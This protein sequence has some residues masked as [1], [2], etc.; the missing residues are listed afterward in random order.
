MSASVRWP[1]SFQPDRQMVHLLRRW[2][3]VVTLLA[4]HAF[5]FTSAAAAQTVNGR[6]IGDSS[7]APIVNLRVLLVDSVSRRAV[8]STN[9][10]SSGAFY[11]QA[12][13]PGTYALAFERANASPSFSRS[14]RLAAGAEQQGIFVVPDANAVR[15]LTAADVDTRAIP[16]R[17]N[18]APRYPDRLRREGVQGNALIRLVVD[19]AGRVVPSTVAILQATAS[20]FGVAAQAAA[21]AW[22]FQ[23]ALRLGRPVYQAACLPTRY[24]LTPGDDHEAKRL[25]SLAGLWGKDGECPQLPASRQPG[26]R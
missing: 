26:I 6:V 20:E 7:R 4:M 22:R 9:T 11:L 14:W 2:Q 21:L 8:D 1:H 10:D 25:D 13:G 16:V 24:R 12:P 17:G 19:P 18:P 3:V 23:P 15:V 5:L